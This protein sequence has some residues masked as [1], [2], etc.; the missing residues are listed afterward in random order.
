MAGNLFKNYKGA[1]LIV[2]HDRFFLDR[3]AEKIIEIDNCRATSFT[4]N[5]TAYA[6][7][8]NS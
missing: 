8:R 7:K 5:Y 3:L 2:S 4:G 6:Q 1:V